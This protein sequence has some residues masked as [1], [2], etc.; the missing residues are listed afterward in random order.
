MIAPLLYFWGDDELPRNGSSRDSPPARR[1]DGGTLER[2]DL[3]GRP[4]HGERADAAQLHERLATPGDVRRR[5]ARGRHEPGRAGQARTTRVTA[6][7]RPSSSSSPRQRARHR[8][9]SAESAR[10]TRARRKL[11]DA[12]KARRR[13]DP[14]RPGAAAGRP[15]RVDRRRGARSGAPAWRR[16]AARELATGSG[17][18]SPRAT[19][20]AATRPA[21]RRGELDKLALCHAIDEVPVTPDDV[22]AL[23]A[24]TTP[25]SVVGPHRRRRRA[26]RR[27]ALAAA[28]PRS[29]DSTPEPVLLAVLHRR[30]VELLELGDRLRGG[31]QPRRGGAGDGDQQRVPG[32]DA[33]EPGAEVDDRPSL[34]R[35]LDGL[36]ELD[37]M[38]KGVAGLRRRRRPASTGVHAL[39]PRSGHARRRLALDERRRTGPV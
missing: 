24:E 17:R 14:R 31:A 39:D 7:S 30:I 1:G 15:R 19:P 6:S 8:R 37:A 11:A 29:L 3:R 25:G 22:R 36:V 21:S 4:Q 5:H 13:G 33:G 16:G 10:R 23:V 18:A 20:I 34:T 32:P 12:I 28:R 9:G 35:A 38:V 2:W 27:R 26:R